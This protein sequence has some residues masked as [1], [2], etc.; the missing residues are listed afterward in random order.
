MLCEKYA[1]FCKLNRKISDV[2][3]GFSLYPHFRDRLFAA[4]KQCRKVGDE[5]HKKARAGMS[6]PA[7]PGSGFSASACY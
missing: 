3:E 4:N 5:E 1:E 6:V 7:R 2:F